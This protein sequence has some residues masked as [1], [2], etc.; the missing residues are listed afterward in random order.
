[1]LFTSINQVSMTSLHCEW[2]VKTVALLVS[3]SAL[4]FVKGN[5]L[6][7]SS[8][9]IWPFTSQMESDI[10]HDNL[11][12]NSLHFLIVSFWCFQ[13]KGL[14]CWYLRLWSLDTNSLHQCQGVKLQLRINRHQHR[15]F[16]STI[17]WSL[18]IHHPR[19][20][21]KQLFASF[22]QLDNFV[23]YLHLYLHFK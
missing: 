16:H 15:C 8:L 21:S 9:T 4:F 22:T 3:K 20:K 23:I 14:C 6:C 19:R 10:L 1:M 5:A 13:K 12:R 2:L 7:V 17:G 18:P 11:K